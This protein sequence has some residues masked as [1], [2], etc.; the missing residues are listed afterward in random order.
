MWRSISRFSVDAFVDSG[1]GSMAL[2][3]LQRGDFPFFYTLHQNIDGDLKPQETTETASN[4][5]LSW[6]HQG[7][8]ATIIVRLPC[9]ALL[10]YLTCT[11]A[12]P[13]S[14]NDRPTIAVTITVTASVE[15]YYRKAHELC[16]ST[17]VVVSSAQPR[18][19]S[20]QG[21][22]KSLQDCHIPSRTPNPF[23]TQPY[24]AQS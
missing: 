11:R 23:P 9:L 18:H 3:M 4:E 2:L 8:S 14:R 21:R 5:T 22:P 20:P 15:K 19:S 1:T 7:P 24:G 16:S 13:P 10:V 6:T 17:S 12:S